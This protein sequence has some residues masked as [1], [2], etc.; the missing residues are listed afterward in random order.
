MAQVSDSA[1]IATVSRHGEINGGV[2]DSLENIQHAHAHQDLL[3][4][5]IDVLGNRFPILEYDGLPDGLAFRIL[6]LL[7]R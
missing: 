5:V 1:T 4:A 7:G 6:S 2:S 3:L